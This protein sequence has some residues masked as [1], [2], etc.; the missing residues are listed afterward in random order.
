MTVTIILMSR[1]VIMLSWILCYN[2]ILDFVYPP[3]AAKPTLAQLM[4]M[5]TAR[6]ERIEIIKCV[7]PQWKQLGIYLD[8][9]PTGRTLDLI[10][11][12]HKFDGPVDCCE[13]TI[14]HWLKGNGIDA[15]WN[16][17]IELLEDIGELELAKQVKSSLHVEGRI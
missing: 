10:E 4:K 7:A 12:K 1:Y 3:S 14:K 9:D 5:K 11:A 8:F 2:V 17:V 15:T 13:A 6:G 16:T